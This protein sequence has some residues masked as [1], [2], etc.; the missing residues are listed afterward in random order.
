MRT[1]LLYLKNSDVNKIKAQVLE[2]NQLDNGDLGLILDQTVFYPQGG[3]QASDKGWMTKG[4]IRS[5]VESVT[6]NNTGVVHIIKPRATNY[7]VGDLVDLEIDEELR[8]LHNR[9]HSAGEL[10]V[11]V[12]H[13]KFKYD[14]WD[15][16]GACHFP[17]QCRIEYPVQI[18]KSLLK[19]I[20]CEVNKI[21]KKHHRID[22]SFSNKQSV[23]KLC[24]FVPDYIPE[25]ERIRVVTVWGNIGRPCKGT[26][27]RF[28]DEIGIINITGIKYRKN[29]SIVSYKLAK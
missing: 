14:S 10:I 1:D 23:E 3:G 24:G 11:A 6:Y 26:H 5:V 2:I 22:I 29:Q 28:L 7:A 20:E 12:L 17:G 8:N 27:V 18:D 9:L 25:D 19:A 4:N 16:S 21:G 15:V 13:N